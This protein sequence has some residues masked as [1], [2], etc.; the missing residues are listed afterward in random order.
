MAKVK[1][2]SE[3]IQECISYIRTVLNDGKWHSIKSMELTQT[4]GVPLYLLNLMVNHK[5]LEKK[6]LDDRTSEYRRLPGLE[7]FKEE[8][9]Q[10]IVK[11]Y[12]RN[13]KAKTASKPLEA[14]LPRITFFSNKDSLPVPVKSLTA[15]AE[16]V[17]EPKTTFSAD[18]RHHSEPGT[19]VSLKIQVWGT[20]DAVTIRRMVDFLLSDL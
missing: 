16:V 17:S 8:T 11:S 10:K 15:P 4:F 13:K 2:T 12:V 18:L 3:N 9:Y 20:R 7:Y 14:E 5:T 6:A 1:T 19:E